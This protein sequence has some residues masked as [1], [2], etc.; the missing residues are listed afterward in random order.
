MQNISLNSA[1]SDAALLSLGDSF[2]F[3]FADFDT[4]YAALRKQWIK[5]RDASSA[6]QRR[7]EEVEEIRLKGVREAREVRIQKKRQRI[8]RAAAALAR[9]RAASEVSAWQN[10][11]HYQQ[12]FLCL[13]ENPLNSQHCKEHAVAWQTFA[14]HGIRGSIH[15]EMFWACYIVI[16][17]LCW[18]SLK[19]RRCISI[20]S[21]QICRLS[22]CRKRQNGVRHLTKSTLDIVELGNDLSHVHL[23]LWPSWRMSGQRCIEED[24]KLFSCSILI[25]TVSINPPHHLG[26]QWNRFGSLQLSIF[27]LV[28]DGLFKHRR[29][30]EPLLKTQNDLAAAVH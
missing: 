23:N 3:I 24:K 29:I 5:E 17:G 6:E 30:F 19:L 4:L 11:F 20:H 18:F 10:F 8:E 22:D 27:F 16:I 14:T 28:L 15:I 26:L 25:L 13:I 1:N 21:I 9:K 12:K 7:Q 2:L